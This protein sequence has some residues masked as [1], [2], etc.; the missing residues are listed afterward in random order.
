MHVFFLIATVV[1]IFAEVASPFNWILI[2][3]GIGVMSTQGAV[4][5]G[6]VHNSLDC[7]SWCLTQ[8]G[9][10][11]TLLGEDEKKIYMKCLDDDERYQQMI[12]GQED[13]GE[14]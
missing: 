6:I 1:V 5:K 2:F 4:F 10:M 7:A 14:Y 8:L 13:D 12:E 11:Y 3:L 9:F